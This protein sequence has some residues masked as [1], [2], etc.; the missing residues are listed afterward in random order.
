[1]ILAYSLIAL[2]GGA[3]SVFGLQ[4]L[5]P[6]AVRFLVWH[7]DAMPLALV[8]ILGLAAGAFLATLMGL[9]RAVRQD[10]RARRL[11]G[12]PD[13]RPRPKHPGSLRAATGVPS[14]TGRRA[15]SGLRA[16][17]T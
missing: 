9:V 3:A 4:N 12:L 2:V 15:P 1:M 7:D 6:V 8:L 13:A 5:D 16:N 11:A 17:G 14:R 10:A